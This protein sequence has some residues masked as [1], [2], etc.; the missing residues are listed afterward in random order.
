MPNFGCWCREITKLGNTLKQF[1]GEKSLKK[2]M[3]N[4]SKITNKII[5]TKIMS[6][7]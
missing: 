5:I 2:I 1:C 4:F 6:Q 7:N 3:K